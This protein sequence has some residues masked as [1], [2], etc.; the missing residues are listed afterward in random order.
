MTYRD[1]LVSMDGGEAQAAT[2][3]FAADVAAK[4]GATLIGA[5]ARSQ[6]GAPFVPPDVTAALSAAEIQRMVDASDK[7]AAAAAEGARRVFEAAAAEQEVSSVWDVVS[8]SEALAACARRTDLFILS[9]A[10][11]TARGGL[12]P[13]SLAMASGGP[14]ILL[15]AG[16][17][18]SAFRR[19]LI[20]WN[21]SR[22]AA[23]ALRSA[24]PLIGLADAVDVV[25]VA[26]GGAD[27]ADSLLQRH[28]EHHGVKPNVIV[29]RGGD[30]PVGVLLQRQ[31]EAA[32][33]DLVVMGLYGRPRLQEQ[34]L[35]GVSRRMLDG[36]KVPLLVSH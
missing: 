2:A 15:P 34:V 19:I 12:E 4:F 14:A 5:Y 26:R 20:A 8:D 9:A 11:E 6:V 25:M 36:P 35:G 32:K 1:I 21:G 23:R 13:A 33:P 17:Q 28:F 24:W 10:S 27:G 7:A 3:R 31:V 22:E 30:A 16:A 29:E 18:P